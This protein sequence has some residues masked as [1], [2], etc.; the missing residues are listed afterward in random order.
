MRTKFDCLRAALPNSRSAFPQV[1]TTLSGQSHPLRQ[2]DENAV[3]LL[4]S[5]PCGR[6]R[7]SRFVG[8][9]FLP[10]LMA[11]ASLQTRNGSAEKFLHLS[12]SRRA[13]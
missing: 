4:L 10:A 7:P 8:G 12:D 11:A 9:E 2:W 3:R 1:P 13:R 5:K 6:M